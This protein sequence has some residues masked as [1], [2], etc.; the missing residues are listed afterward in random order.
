MKGLL[1]KDLLNL[2]KYGRTILLLSAFYLLFGLMSDSFSML[3]GMI[4]LLFSMV[5]ITSFS[6][7]DLAKWNTYALAMP[8]SRRNVV[9]GK[10]TLGAL[11]SLVGVLVS[12][13]SIV[14]LS[15]IKG[16]VITTD[17]LISCYLMLSITVLFNTLLLPL[18]FKFGVEKSRLF[19]MAIFAVPTAAF[20]VISN[21]GVSLPSLPESTAELLL[22]LTLPFS[23]ALFYAS[24]HISCAIFRK[25]EL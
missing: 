14:V 18:I 8:V 16:S 15:L 2:R 7:D 1:L 11:F 24:F 25:K 12:F 22:Y 13:L 17:D 6:Y 21:T 3:T 23:L 10:Y 5:S 4:A 20:L 19:I 9:A